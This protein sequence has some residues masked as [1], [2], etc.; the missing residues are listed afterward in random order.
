[1]EYKTTQWN[2]YYI[3]TLIINKAWN[4]TNRRL[5][6]KPSV[7]NIPSKQLIVRVP[8]IN[9]NPVAMARLTY[10][11][12]IC[13]LPIVSG[14]RFIYGLCGLSEERVVILLPL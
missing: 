6:Q 12:L 3:A 2:F 4:R 14:L 1:M 5:N 11:A 10:I 8:I 13:L 9:H 7:R